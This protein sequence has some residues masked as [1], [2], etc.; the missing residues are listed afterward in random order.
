MAAEEK[1]LMDKEK[2]NPRPIGWKSP[3][4]HE[5]STLV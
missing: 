3:S 2:D 1:L 4:L 5:E